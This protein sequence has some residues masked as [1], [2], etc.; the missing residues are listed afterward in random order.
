M[1]FDLIDLRLGLKRGLDVR[2]AELFNT[3][4]LGQLQSVPEAC[5]TL[6]IQCLNHMLTCDLLNLRA[7]G[8]GLHGS[9]WKKIAAQNAILS[10][11]PS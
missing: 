8:M 10:L 3:S 1:C 9:S 5:W 4:H 6:R 7:E 11:H 2:S